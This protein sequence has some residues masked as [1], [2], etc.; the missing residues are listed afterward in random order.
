MAE[1][2][3]QTIKE[4]SSLAM[5]AVGLA[6]WVHGENSLDIL[7]QAEG[8]KLERVMG[9]YDPELLP[10]ATCDRTSDGTDEVEGEPNEESTTSTSRAGYSQNTLWLAATIMGV[11]NM[12]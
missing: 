4:D 10:D 9:G 2:I 5:F 1:R 12:L 7:L 3:V 11:L 8:Y 6:H